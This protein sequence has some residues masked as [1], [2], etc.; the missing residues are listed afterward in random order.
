MSKSIKENTFL[1]HFSDYKAS[2]RFMFTQTSVS[3]FKN[4]FHKIKLGFLKSVK[5]G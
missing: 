4:T 1:V 2:S 5:E 3:L